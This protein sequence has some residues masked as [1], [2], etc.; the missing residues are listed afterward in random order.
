MGKCKICGKEFE[1]KSMG[2]HVV[3]AHTDLNYKKWD[4]KRKKD[5]IIICLNCGKEV[6]TKDIKRKRKFCCKLCFLT[7]YNNK[8]TKKEIIVKKEIILLSKSS[9]K[10]VFDRNK[11]WQSARSSIRR[12]AQKI[13]ET[14][15]KEKKCSVC[16]Y[17][18]HVE[19][20][21][22]KSVSSFNDDSLIE[23]IN[24]I[25]NLIALC[26]NHHWEFDNDKHN[27]AWQK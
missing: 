4:S 27:A 3:S 10:E 19:I 25:D 15:G 21:H 16:G 7:F 5:L 20:C 2:G 26:P 18:N 1:N 17:K 22:I 9:K 13:F 8:K 14:S 12:N 24:H 6:K 23:E 11:N